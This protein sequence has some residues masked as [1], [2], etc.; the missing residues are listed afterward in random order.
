RYMDASISMIKR[1]FLYD[2]I[3]YNKVLANRNKVLK[4]IKFKS[5]NLKLLDIM[6]EQLSIYG[7][8]IMMYRKQY[9]NNLNLIVKKIL[10]DISDEEVE[11][12]YW[13]NVMDKIDDIKY[14]KESLSN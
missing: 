11:I 14:I 6:D 4:D 3:Q 13:S 9:I 12:C 5:E 8:K 1:N 10:H 2:I 7:S